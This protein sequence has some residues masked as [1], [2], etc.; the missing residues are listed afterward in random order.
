LTVL[1]VISMILEMKS[2]NHKSTTRTDL[3]HV[4][5]CQVRN[6][7]HQLDSDSICVTCWQINVTFNFTAST[8]YKQS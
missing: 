4:L 3:R 2:T 1:T 5:T 7:C 6:S 8:G